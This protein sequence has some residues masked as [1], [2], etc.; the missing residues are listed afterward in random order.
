MIWIE[1]RCSRR[2]NPKDYLN[3]LCWSDE[4]FG[5]MGGAQDNLTDV[6]AV[7]AE[8]SKQ[9]QASGWKNIRGEGWVC[10]HCVS[11]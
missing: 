3:D 6:K 4:N 5:P 7:V 11:E 10:P 9:A 8:L 2:R 1:F